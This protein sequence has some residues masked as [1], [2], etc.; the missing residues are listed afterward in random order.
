MNCTFRRRQTI[1]LPGIVIF[2][3]IPERLLQRQQGIGAGIPIG[4]S[5]LILFA[6]RLPANRRCCRIDNSQLRRGRLPSIDCRCEHTLSPPNCRAASLTAAG[7]VKSCLVSHQRSITTQR[8]HLHVG[9][10][11]ARDGP[12]ST[13]VYSLVADALSS[14]ARRTPADE[15]VRE[16]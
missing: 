13:P 7:A 10:G 5:G 1:D 3:G 16:E 14:P 12:Q 15:P 6:G 4:G 11:V 9:E 8:S 2:P